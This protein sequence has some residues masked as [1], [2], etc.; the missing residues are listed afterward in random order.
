VDGSIFLITFQN[1]SW[2]AFSASCGLPVIRIARL[3]ARSPNVA[4][5]DSAPV[6]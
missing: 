2:R 4:T 5:R 1:A 6:A 3:Y